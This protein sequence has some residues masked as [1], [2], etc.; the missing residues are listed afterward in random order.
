PGDILVGVRQRSGSGSNYK[1]ICRKAKFRPALRLVLW[2]ENVRINSRRNDSRT[3]AGSNDRATVGQI[4]Q[5]LAVGNKLHA[6]V[7]ICLQFPVLVVLW[8]NA[9]QR[10]LQDRTWRAALSE[11]MAPAIKET[12]AREMPHIV[13]SDDNT[14]PAWQFLQPTGNIKPICHGVYMHQIET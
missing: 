11:T 14:Y 8:Q 1:G 10:H 9:I 5:P 6:P 3:A 13:Q 12:T 2:P 7:S 4:R